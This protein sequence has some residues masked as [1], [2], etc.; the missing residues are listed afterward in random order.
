MESGLIFKCRF[1]TCFLSSHNNETQ[2]NGCWLKT[3]SSSV[4]GEDAWP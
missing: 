1:K 2:L 3:S 4:L